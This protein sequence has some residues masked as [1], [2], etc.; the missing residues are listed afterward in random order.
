[1]FFLFLLICLFVCCLVG[2]SVCRVGRRRAWRVGLMWGGWAGVS[3]L[4]RDSLCDAR[5]ASCWDARGAWHVWSCARNRYC[6]CLKV[7][8]LSR[9]QPLP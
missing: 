9:L 2:L 1:V 6:C 5:G 3:H 4:V 7:G 8:G